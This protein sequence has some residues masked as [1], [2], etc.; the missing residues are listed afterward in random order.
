MS[1]KVTN[2]LPEIMNP[3]IIPVFLA[4]RDHFGGPKSIFLLFNFQ[5][6][7]CDEVGFIVPHRDVGKLR[8]HFDEDCRLQRALPALASFIKID[9]KL[10]IADLADDLLFTLLVHLPFDIQF[11]AHIH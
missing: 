11:L 1:H 5:S 8:N 2:S 7:G 10:Q 9:V 6:L 3:L 4:S